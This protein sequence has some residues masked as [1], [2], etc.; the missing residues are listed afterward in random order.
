MKLTIQH[1]DTLGAINS[2]LCVI[3]CFAT[4]FLF[5]TQAQTSLVE[6]STVPLWWQ[7]LNYVFI[8][9][10]FFAVNRTVKNSSNQL[11]KSLLWVS[12]VLLSAL[13]LNEEFEIMHMPELLT[14]FAGISLASL[15][16]YNLKYCQCEDENCCPPENKS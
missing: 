8:V 12:W 6:L 15:H 5:L 3:H 1:P 13:I 16:I 4:P 7:L 14:Y 2:S 9:V 11:V 10:S